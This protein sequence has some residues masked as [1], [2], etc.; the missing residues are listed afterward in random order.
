M[1]FGLT[2][3]STVFQ[4]TMNDIFWEHI[5]DFVVIHL[6]DILIYSKNEEDHTKHVRL[7]LEK[8]RGQRLYSKR[9]K[10][11]FYQTEMEFLGFIATT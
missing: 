1:S 10:C 6:D 8:L 4:H 7:V 5:D 3:V 11:L 9:K 2:N